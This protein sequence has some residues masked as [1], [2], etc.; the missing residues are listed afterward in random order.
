MLSLSKRIRR[1]IDLAKLDAVTRAVVRDRLTYLSYEKLERIQRALAET[2]DR[3]GDIIEFGVALGGSGII[4][5]RG[6]GAS[7]R[8]LGFDV[9]GMIPPPTSEKDDA[10][11][12]LRYEV[13]SSGK[14]RGINGDTYYGYKKDLFNEVVDSFARHGVEADGNRVFLHK[15]LFESTWSAADESIDAIALAHI[16]C[17]WYDPVLFCLNACADKLVEG[18]ILIIDDYNDYGGC[19]TAVDEFVSKRADFRLEPGANP[20]LRKCGGLVS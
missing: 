11:S 9:F 13:I 3:R 12:K 7:R 15:G 20:F 17:D 1:Y 19:R 2:K 14:S 18:G 10:K 5:A 6:A 4:L 8:F 16:D